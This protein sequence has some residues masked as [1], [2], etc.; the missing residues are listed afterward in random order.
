MP[1][2]ANSGGRNARTP[3]EHRQRGTFRKNLH[4]GYE[5]PEHPA[6]KPVPPKELT[7][8]AAAEWDRMIARLEQ[9]KTLSTIDDAALYQ[10][11]Q[12]FAEVESIAATHARLEALSRRLQGE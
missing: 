11:V 4:G 2:T 10:Y 5:C 8:D 7:G 3:E 12:L 6:G 9:A 1:G